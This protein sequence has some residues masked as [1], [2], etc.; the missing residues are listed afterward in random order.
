[1]KI[2][3]KS[4]ILGVLLGVC[5]YSWSLLMELFLYQYGYYRL[6]WIVLNFT[7]LPIIFSV[8]TVGYFYFIKHYELKVLKK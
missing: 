6:E 8:A 4:F 7:V 2:E 1:M 3:N 5:A